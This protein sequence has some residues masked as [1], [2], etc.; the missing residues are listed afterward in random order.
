MHEVSESRLPHPLGRVE[1]GHHHL[2]LV[3]SLPPGLDLNVWE[4]LADVLDPW[5]INSVLGIS[6]L[7]L[8]SL[9]SND[10]LVRSLAVLI[11]KI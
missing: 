5:M 7:Q 3:G 6:S 1:I 9:V 4:S 10:V 2:M 11:A 8:D